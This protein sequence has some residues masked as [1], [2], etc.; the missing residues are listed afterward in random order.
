MMLSSPY[1]IYILAAYGLS[2]IGLG[3]FF[4]WTFFSWKR[5]SQKSQDFSKDKL[6]G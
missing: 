4:A 6:E 2:L 3:A 5:S 1:L